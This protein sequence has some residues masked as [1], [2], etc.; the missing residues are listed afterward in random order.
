[1]ID[2]EG[3]ELAENLTYDQHEAEHGNGE[4]HINEQF[5]ADESVDQFHRLSSVEQFARADK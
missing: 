4:E 2:E 1:M 3:Q 5:A